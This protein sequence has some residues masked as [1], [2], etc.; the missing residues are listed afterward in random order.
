MKVSVS[1]SAEDLATVD[2]YA[3]QEGVP[4]RSAVIQRAIALLRQ[5]SLEDD[6]ANAWDEWAGTGE[7]AAWEGSLA[8]G[9]VEEPNAGTGTRASR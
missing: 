4:S 6:Y 2:W 5:R 8:D 7:A 1:L 3:R 9:L